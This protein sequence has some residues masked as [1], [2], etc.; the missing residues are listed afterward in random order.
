MKSVVK[1]IH[2]TIICAYITIILTTTVVNAQTPASCTMDYQCGT[3]PYGQCFGSVNDCPTTI[4]GVA[5]D[6]SN[7]QIYYGAQCRGASGD[8]SNVTIKTVSGNGGVATTVFSEPILRT[9]GNIVK[10]FQTVNGVLYWDRVEREPGSSLGAFNLKSKSETMVTLNP[11]FFEAQLE[12][13]NGV[14]YSCQL[15]FGANNSYSIVRYE[16][17]V[18]QGAQTTGRMIYVLGSSQC[19]PVR[20]GTG[21]E[22]YFTIITVTPNPTTIATYTT[23]FYRG[24]TSGSSTSTLPSPLF[25]VN[26]EVLDFDVD[27]T[28]SSIIYGTR[29]GL[30]KRVG[31]TTKTLNNEQITGL[32]IY[33]QR[34]IYNNGVTIR[35]TSLDGQDTKDLVQSTTGTCTCRAGFYGNNCQSCNGQVQWNN[36]SPSCVATNGAGVPAT[37]SFDYQCGNVPYTVC[38]GSCSCR[39]NFTGDKCDKCEGAK[40]ISFSNGIPACQ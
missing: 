21:S 11:G 5:V 25:V 32:S 30:F 22:L 18:G 34:I 36:G 19:G 28:S 7:N 40:T 29:D 3:I 38:T 24:S 1:G 10:V 14:S 9:A 26:G 39:G 27:T 35:S 37:C 12:I 33:Y 8:T 20:V 15:D 2:S 31:S 6:T 23:T 17:I 4:L 16:G 13:V